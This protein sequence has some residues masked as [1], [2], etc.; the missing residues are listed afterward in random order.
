MCTAMHPPVPRKRWAAALAFVALSYAYEYQLVTEEMRDTASSIY[1]AAKQ[2]NLTYDRLA[3]A[4]T[5]FGP[6]FSGSASLEAALDWIVATASTQDNIT[7]IQQE[8]W[9]PKWVRGTEWAKMV[10]PRNASLHMVGLGMS[11]GSG[12]VIEAEVLAVSSDTEL[13]SRCAEAAGK[14]VLFNAPFVTY[15]QTVIYRSEAARWAADCG[16]V[17]ALI[18]SITPFGIQTPHTGSSNPSTI[19]SAALSI[20]DAN[21]IQRLQSYGMPVVV[22]MFMGA[23]LFNDSL[24]R[25]VIMEIPGSELPG[26]YVVIGGHSDSWDIAAGAMDDGGGS[27]SSWEAVRLISSLGLK[28]RRTIRAVFWVNEENG[29]DGGTAYAADND[30]GNHSIA[31]ET[32]EGAFT[33]YGFSFSGH[34]AAFNQLVILSELLATIGA[35]N[36]TYTT[37]STGTDVGPMCAAG[38]PC[39]GLDVLDP[40]IGSYSNNPCAPYAA[41]QGAGTVG[42]ISNGYFWYHH[43]EAGE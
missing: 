29:H 38:V 17:G 10:S 7:V 32:D 16:A 41:T 3:Y 20:E 12:G 5:V 39:G 19:P 11:I 33:P 40:R 36:L 21:M 23:Q 22:Q 35:G 28:P 26:E 37:G 8:V 14:I 13:D 42:Q 9:V 2:S 6:R 27:F 15:G 30:I 1:A 31:I 4:T 34:Q 43:T 24:S 18:R 25:N